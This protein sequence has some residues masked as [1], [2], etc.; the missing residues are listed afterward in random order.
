M[1]PACIEQS[2]NVACNFKLVIFT[3]DAVHSLLFFLVWDKES[4]ASKLCA[5]FNVDKYCSFSDFMISVSKMR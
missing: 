2:N 1:T 5:V 3:I 4:D